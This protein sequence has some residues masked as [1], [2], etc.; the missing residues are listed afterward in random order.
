MNLLIV[1]TA[2]VG[3]ELGNPTITVVESTKVP[4]TFRDGVRLK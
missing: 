2:L 1:N 4:K 3:L